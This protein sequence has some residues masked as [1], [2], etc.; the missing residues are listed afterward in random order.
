MSE[1]SQKSRSAVIDPREAIPADFER[2]AP[3]GDVRK[4]EDRVT[5]ESVW[6]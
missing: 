2:L 3:L 1:P 5:G 4:S 6:A